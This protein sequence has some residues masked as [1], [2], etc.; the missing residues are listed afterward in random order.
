M[1]KSNLVDL[2]K[3]IKSSNSSL[4]KKMPRFVIS[5]LKKLI[6]QDEINKVVNDNSDKYG[7]D[8]VMAVMQYLNSE[9]KP[10]WIEEKFAHKKYIFVC[11]HPLGG[12]DFFAAILAISSRIDRFKVIANE[13]L[14]NLDNLKELF[15]P[16]NVFGRSPQHYYNMMNEAYASD[17]AIM[18]FPAGEVSRKRQGVIQDAEWHRSF[19][20]QAISNERD[21]VPVY[22][23]AKNSKRFYNLGVWRKRLGIKLNLELMLLPDELFKQ[24][25]VTIPVVVGKPIPYSTFDKSKKH[26]E[27]AQYV[28]KLVYDLKSTCEPK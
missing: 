11:N 6:H 26:H 13:I 19:I 4:L 15:L 25:N 16:V 10:I 12:V 22:I 27:W 28:R 7:L 23:H 9:V 8:F 14:M 21:I 5:Y 20:R 3:I 1:T 18:T 2:D 24:R 17:I